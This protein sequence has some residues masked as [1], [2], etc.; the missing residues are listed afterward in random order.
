MV[1]QGNLW[2]IIRG[3]LRI[4]CGGWSAAICL[5]GGHRVLCQWG[6]RHGE[7]WLSHGGQREGRSVRRL[8]AGIDVAIA[9]ETALMS[10]P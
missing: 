4:T 6:P 2:R 3:V 10:G 7:V 9:L 1:D 8:S 5:L